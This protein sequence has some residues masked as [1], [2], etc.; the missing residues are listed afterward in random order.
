M[1]DL[2]IISTFT[3][4]SGFT[5]IQSSQK[6]SRKKAIKILSSF[7]PQ[8]ASP[9]VS[10]RIGTYQS[11]I[12]VG[13]YYMQNDET[14]MIYTQLISDTYEPF[15]PFN[16]KLD[17]S[18]FDSNSL[19][20]KHNDYNS[21]ELFNLLDEFGL[22]GSSSILYS[23]LSGDNIIIVDDSHERRIKLIKTFLSF[24]PKLALRYNRITT[25]CFDLDGNENIIGVK[26]LPKKF[27]SHKKLYF[28]LDTI[29]V[30]IEERKLY[31][32]GIKTNDFIQNLLLKTQGSNNQLQNE[33]E[34]LFKQISARKFDKEEL[35]P[36]I[37]RISNRLSNQSIIND[38]WILDF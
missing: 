26:V 30:D 37:I 12:G 21:E 1:D 34:Q 16:P 4:N 28:P 22:E 17:L 27:R 31:G 3:R 33:F 7:T 25:D 20:T 19:V 8:G 14:A 9:L 24:L 23:I 35:N 13:Y 32:N 18:T 5:K 6:L 29:F 11:Y 36:L 15:K 2:S 10:Y 38:T